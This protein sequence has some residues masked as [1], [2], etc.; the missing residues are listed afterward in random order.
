MEA[1]SSLT[2]GNR[3][4]RHFSIEIPPNNG[5]VVPP[6]NQVAASNPGIRSFHSPHPREDEFRGRH[7]EP[8]ARG[9]EIRRALW[10]HT[11]DTQYHWKCHCPSTSCTRRPDGGLPTGPRSLR[12]LLQPNHTGAQ[13][14]Q[15]TALQIRRVSADDKIFGPKNR[16]QE[17]FIAHHYPIVAGYCV[18]PKVFSMIQRLLF[19]QNAKPRGGPHCFV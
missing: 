9:S 11:P 17:I 13:R 2:A 1:L 5:K 12:V 7:L 8:N 18:V 6:L 16:I 3:I 15:A 10:T 19:P 14:G 4:H